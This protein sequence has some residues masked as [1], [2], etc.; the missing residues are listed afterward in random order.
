MPEL[1]GCGYAGARVRTVLDMRSGVQFSETYLD[2]TSEVR[3]M[4]RSVGWAP[5]NPATRWAC[6]PTS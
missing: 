1:A 2:P 3:V 6:I 4:E 5:R